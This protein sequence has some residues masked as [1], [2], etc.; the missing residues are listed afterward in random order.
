MKTV[1]IICPSHRDKRELRDLAST[2]GYQIIFDV[3]MDKWFERIIQQ[4]PD[5]ILPDAIPHTK[6]ID[7][8]K[9]KYAHLPIDG[10]TSSTDYP[11]SMFASIFAHHLGHVGV[12]PLASLLCHHKYY[13][14]QAQQNIVPNA[15]P[16]FWLLEPHDAPCDL[17]FPVFVKPVK[18]YFSKNTRTATNAKDLAEARLTCRFPKLYTE[19]LTYFI[20]QFVPN[21]IDAQAL[22]AEELLTG[23][24][25]TVE[26][27]AHNSHA[28]TFGIVDSTMYPGTIS[29]KQFEYPSTLPPSIQERMKDIASTFIN[30]IDF[31]TGLFNI[32]MIYNEEQNVIHIIE[33]NP[34]M[35][36]QFADLYERVDGINTYQ[37]LLELAVG[38]NP[39]VRKNKGSFSTAASF[40]LR[41]FKDK[42]VKKIPTNAEIEKIRTIFPDVRIEIFAQ[43]GK[44][45]SNELQ[46]GMSY[47]YALIN[48][49]GTD[50]L[51]LLHRL[52]VCLEHLP[53]EFEDV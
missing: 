43:E 47:R 49:G 14:R 26:G 36:N 37:L 23:K 30:A 8:L 9:E 34:R 32:E 20:Q 45:L 1:V 50:N 27:Y 52:N 3:D 5:A 6:L 42:F 11:G 35:S 46:D 41:L 33:I 12:N 19:P 4:E 38:T 15:T 10:I 31:G 25:V 48:L 28:Y 17:T 7:C 21:A 44:K 13:S 40:V 2:L 39:I 51:D 22:L 53:F 18:S 29:F 16:R 24:Q